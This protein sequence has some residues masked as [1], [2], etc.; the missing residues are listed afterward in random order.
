MFYALYGGVV[1][2]VAALLYIAH[3]RDHLVPFALALLALATGAFAFAYAANE[4]R[5]R[6]ADGWADCWPSCTAIQEA[7]RWG[8]F[9][10][11]GILLV[12][13]FALVFGGVSRRRSK[14]E[15]DGAA[16]AG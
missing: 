5:W 7:T 16:E 3:R 9:L 8:L 11:P 10:S 1:V 12:V 2:A 6:D 14:R 13:A 15:G 4:T